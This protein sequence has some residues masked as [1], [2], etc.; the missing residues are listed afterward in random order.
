MAP[1]MAAAL[2][3]RAL[4]LHSFLGAGA[5][6]LSSMGPAVHP[7]LVVEAERAPDWTWTIAPPMRPKTA[8]PSLAAAK[9]ATQEADTRKEFGNRQGEE[10]MEPPLV[11]QAVMN[12]SAPGL[13][14]APPL[15]TT[16]QANWERVEE[17]LKRGRMLA[18]ETKVIFAGLVR[19]SAFAV[20]PAYKSLMRIASQFL[21]YRFFFIEN[22]SS[23]GTQWQLFDISH[24]DPKFKYLSKRLNLT[25]TRGL[26]TDRMVRMADLRN[27][28]RDGIDG[29]LSKSTS[30]QQ[31]QTLIVMVDMD[32]FTNGRNVISPHPFFSML[33]R[34]ET[35][36]DKW[37]MVCANSLWHNPSVGLSMYDCFAWRDQAND[38]F[39]GKDC[40]GDVGMKM[41][42]GYDLV[43]VHS[44]F[45]GMAVYK[46]RS[47]LKCRYDP[48]VYDCEHVVL[49]KCMREHGSRNRMFMDPLMTM[50]YDDMIM[51][52]CST[53]SEARS[54]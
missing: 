40:G 9:L 50:N 45:G 36:R 1:Q 25:D 19:N 23:D 37:D 13:C 48:T 20:N 39:N 2:G 12:L 8:R 17:N 28:L 4:A 32:I 44:C 54:Q 27:M 41:F 46:P 43:P 15:R 18:A 52:A 34:S 6:A 35:T 47:F 51:Q 21:D 31:D 16:I 53:D 33:G 29:F 10:E 7:S 14:Y 30:W 38:A 5:V 22:D 11:D 26:E 24:K 49:H 3:R 42:D